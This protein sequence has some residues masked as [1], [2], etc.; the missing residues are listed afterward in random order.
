[1]SGT[2][3]LQGKTILA[4]DDEPSVLEVLSDEL[5]MCHVVT[6]TT[7]HEAMEC[8]KTYPSEKMEAYEISKMVNSPANDRP[9][10][11]TPAHLL[12]NDSDRLF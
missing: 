12:S 7:Y 11:I 8:L 2:S 6:K 10:C 3:P 9:E 1:M 4:V 5:D